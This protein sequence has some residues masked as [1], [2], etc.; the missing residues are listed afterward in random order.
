MD[1][2]LSREDELEA[3][4]P[5]AVRGEHGI[6]QRLVREADVQLDLGF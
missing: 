6:A 4:Q 2:H 5:H 3:G 1:A